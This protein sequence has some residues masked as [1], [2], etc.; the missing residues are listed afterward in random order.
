MLTENQQKLQLSEVGRLLGAE[1]IVKNQL[2][3]CREG[4][5]RKRGREGGMEEGKKEG[6]K[7]LFII[8]TLMKIYFHTEN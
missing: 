3:F 2:D 4:R 5:G 1:S 6:R 8:E 7:V